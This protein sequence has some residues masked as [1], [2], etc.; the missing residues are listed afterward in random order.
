MNKTIKLLTALT[1]VLAMLMAFIPANVFAAT[2]TLTTGTITVDTTDSSTRSVTL[3]KLFNITSA[4]DA[5]EYSYAFANDD[6]KAYFTS[7]DKTNIIAAIEYVN[8]LAGNH[9][10][11]NTFA[12]AIKD[13][14]ITG[15]TQNSNVDF[16]NQ[17]SGYY[18]L[19]DNT[20]APDASSTISAVVLGNVVF[21]GTTTTYEVELKLDTIAAPVLKVADNDD[22]NALVD[23]DSA[24]PGENVTFV[25][26][27]VI[28][29]IEPAYTAYEMN[30]IDTLPVG[31]VYDDT[32]VP[33]VKIGDT[34]FAATLDDTTPGTLKWTFNDIDAIRAHAGET[35]TIT[36]KTNVATTGYAQTNTNSV[37]TTYTENPNAATVNGTTLA[38]T[39]DVYCYELSLSKI[40]G[41]SELLDGAVFTITGPSG[42]TNTVTVT[43]GNIVL[44]GLK[45]G[46]YTL[47]ETTA[48][49]GYTLLDMPLKI[50]ITDKTTLTGSIAITKTETPAN[51][52]RFIEVAVDATD[53][54]QVNVN[55]INV[56]FG[57][58]PTTGGMGTVVFTVVGLAVMAGAAVVLVKRNRKIEE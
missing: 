46:T 17:T 27:Q 34:D 12:L 2:L 8:G 1:V 33:T 36:Y 30:V 32:F 10:A 40:N 28:P 57:V 49:E 35:I 50:T 26:T 7:I 51:Q 37:V 56:K 31:L 9:S 5:N 4:T 45:E 23:W 6:V 13:S 20:T 41:S 43:N 47:T 29:T 11:L 38:D 3:Y 53:A 19:V 21:S 18:L 22:N 54:L 39:V 24:L 16:E 48:P 15:T 14:G 44:T 55:V 42:Y 25:I 52:Q 58:L